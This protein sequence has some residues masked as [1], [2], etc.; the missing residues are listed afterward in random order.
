MRASEV[1]DRLLLV[2]VDVALV[3]YHSL[4]LVER[5]GEAAGAGEGVGSGC[6]THV[7]VLALKSLGVNR[8]GALL[9]VIALGDS[10]AELLIG[11]L[12]STT[13]HSFFDNETLITASHADELAVLSLH[14]LASNSILSEVT[15]TQ[16]LL[17]GSIEVTLLELG[18]LGILTIS[19]F[20]LNLTLDFA[21]H[22]FSLATNSSH[23]SGRVLASAILCVVGGHELLLGLTID[24]V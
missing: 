2:K 7:S 13:V 14:H 5:L 20:L 4:G 19:H 17:V 1:N 16:V 23:S 18:L 9:R 15:T 3:S 11:C 24:S 6:G 8:D 22:D 10:S 21:L 12:G